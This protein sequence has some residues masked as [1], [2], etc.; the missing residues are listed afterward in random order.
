MRLPTGSP[1]GP[2]ADLRGF[3][4]FSHGWTWSF[5]GIAV[6]MRWDAFAFPG[7]VFVVLGGIG[8]MLGGLVMSLVVDGT[9]GL[10]DLGR[11]TVDPRSIP[12][13]WWL[14]VL[15]F[16]PAVTAVAAVLAIA[17]GLTRDPV[18]LDGALELLA[19]PVSV[20]LYAGFV[21]LLGP[22]P[23][24]IGWRGFLLDRL[25]RRWSALTASLL[26][27][28]AWLTWHLPLFVMVGYYEAAGGPPAPVPFAVGIVVASIFYT[29][30]HN[31][32]G[33]SVLGAILF[34]FTQNFTGQFLD[35]AD[36]TRTLQ[37]VLFVALAI[38]VVA[39]WGPARLRR[40]G[41]RTAP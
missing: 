29:W 33:R 11:R 21:L 38:L 13:R 22:L 7:L 20:L 26:V 25:Q 34:H 31:N 41:P 8:P 30:I 6:A 14:V 37:A 4:L 27:G 3:L 28:V 19:D 18:E 10:R 32:T 2:A 23:E 15:C 17:F 9:A 39:W 16:V 24:E 40:S 36:E 1:F 5:W 35:I 12:G